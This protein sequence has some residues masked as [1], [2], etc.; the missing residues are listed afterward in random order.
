[1]D[2]REAPCPCVCVFECVRL[3]PCLVRARAAR[4]CPRVCACCQ[5][6]DL[7]FVVVYRRYSLYRDSEDYLYCI[8]AKSVDDTAI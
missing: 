6:L 1:M 5:C 3:C 2:G 7:Y 4:A 8:K